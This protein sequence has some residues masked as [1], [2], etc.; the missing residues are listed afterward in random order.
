MF[1][2][3]QHALEGNTATQKYGKERVNEG[4]RIL[5]VVILLGTRDMN[6]GKEYTKWES[7]FISLS[8]ST[9][10]PTSL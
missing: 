7:F 9:L 10:K 3:A 5:Y 8:L 2:S 1:P 6:E 4:E